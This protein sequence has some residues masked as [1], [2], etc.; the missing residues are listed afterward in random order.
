MIVID[1]K[2]LGIKASDFNGM[3][4]QITRAMIINIA[5]DWWMDYSDSDFR[6][7]EWEIDFSREQVIIPD[8]AIIH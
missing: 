3:E 7:F 8:D 1:F 4:F 5:C 2:Q 6:H